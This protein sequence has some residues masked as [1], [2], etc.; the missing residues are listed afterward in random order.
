MPAKGLTGKAG[1]ITVHGN[2]I[3]ITKMTDKLNVEFAD[4]TD[5]SNYDPTSGNLFK[6]QLSGDQQMEFTIEG[7]YDLN[8]TPAN[9]TALVQ[10]PSGGPYPCV[11]ELDGK[12]QRFNGSVDLYDVETTCEVPGAVMVSFT[13]TAK[14]NGKYTLT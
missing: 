14:S 12:N 3:A 11:S 6:A 10:N 8:S 13:C 5:S 7:F 2:V 4:S 1:T 9:L